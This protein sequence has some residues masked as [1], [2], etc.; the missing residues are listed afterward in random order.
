MLVISLEI[1]VTLLETVSRL[2]FV[3]AAIPTTSPI[4][5]SL[6]SPLL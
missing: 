1:L 5:F 3:A 2:V 4:V 6:G